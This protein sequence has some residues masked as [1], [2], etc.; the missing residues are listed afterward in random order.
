MGDGRIALILD[1]NNLSRI[2]HL[3]S[4][5]GS[6][7]A[8]EVAQAEKKAKLISK[9]KQAFL[10]F[11]SS[12]EEQFGVPL[13]Q[14]ERIEKI[15]RSD[16]ENLGGK[17]VLKYRGGSLNLICIDDVAM[18]QPLADRESY[19]VIVFKICNRPIGLL[20]IGP[21]DAAEI[22]IDID[23]TTLVQP[24][25]MGSI[26]IDMQTTMLVNMFEIVQTLLP[27]WFEG[28]EKY[29]FSSDIE[30]KPATILLVEDSKFFRN[31]A[32]KYMTEV[33][34]DIIEAEDGVEA[35]DLLQQNSD[36]VTM[37]VTDIEM[38]NMD[39]LELAK[40]VR[41]NDKFSKM[42][43][44]ALTSLASEEDVERGRAAGIDEYHIK[45]DREE[46]MAS[47]HRYMKNLP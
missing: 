7:R 20:S 27:Q 28:Q 10:I 15:D 32:S 26:I 6:D 13:N 14:V 41:S 1:V 5:D 18:V 8:T 29:V 31:Q 40:K 9:E 35:W 12:E 38:P 36:L 11:K 17:R 34:Y 2:A 16:I 21:V 3:T 46:L 19:L 33:G 44:L 39:G 45:F 23:A 4:V 24:G 25:I 47:V 37:L 43:I 30:D 42:P 22:S